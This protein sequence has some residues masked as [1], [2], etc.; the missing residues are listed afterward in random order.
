MGS[1]Y[2]PSNTFEFQ[3]MMHDIRNKASVNQ[4]QW[5]ISQTAITE[6]DM[7]LADFDAAVAISE[8]P[9]TRTAASIA[10]R[11]LAR[12]NLEKVGRPFI[13]GHLM[14]NRRV[15]ADEL[16][17]MGL[18]VRDLHPT[19]VPDPDEAPEL[20][21]APDTA[22]VVKIRFRRVAGHAKPRGVKTIEVCMLVSDNSAPPTEWTELHESVLATRSPMRIIRGGHERSKWLH[23]AGR[24]VNTRGVKGPWSDIISVVIP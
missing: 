14:N 23:L 7:P 18:P 8:N 6:L 1:N 11:E 5:D 15:T 19:P 2:L 21:P 20:E 16:K 22:G 3:N 12:K 9:E 17:A 13:Q 4:T 10:K 24:W